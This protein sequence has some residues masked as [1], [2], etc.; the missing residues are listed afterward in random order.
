MNTNVAEHEIV[1]IPVS[2][3]L[4]PLAGGLVSFHAVYDVL[5]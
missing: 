4:Y 1:E 5:I 2:P 3:S